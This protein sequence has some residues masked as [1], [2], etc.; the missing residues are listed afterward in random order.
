MTT[1]KPAAEAAPLF[2]DPMPALLRAR[3]QAE[4]VARRTRTSL[5]IA[6]DG[7]LVLVRPR[8]RSRAKRA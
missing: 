2:P 3:K 4:E 8:A 5:V 6:R 7:K 1:K